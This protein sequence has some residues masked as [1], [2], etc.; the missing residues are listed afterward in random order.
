ME[1]VKTEYNLKKEL[2]YGGIFFFILLLFIL[3]FV[4]VLDKQL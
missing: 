1:N 4:F 2:I 3:V